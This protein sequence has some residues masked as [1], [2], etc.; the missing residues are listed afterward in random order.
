MSTISY[1]AAASSGLHLLLRRMRQAILPGSHTLDVEGLPDHLKRDL[2]L[3]GGRAA[4]PR[5]PLR[6]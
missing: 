4:P 6:D 2:G 3:M 5:D 1:A